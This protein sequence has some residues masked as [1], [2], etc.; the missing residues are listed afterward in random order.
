VDS[1][2]S[3]NDNIGVS[4]TRQAS[5][6]NVVVS[7]SSG[8]GIRGAGGGKLVIRDS[9]IEQNAGHGID[10]PNNLAGLKLRGTQVTA[11]WLS[12]LAW[13]DQIS[14]FVL[15]K[16]SVVDSTF[17][18]NGT[19]PLCGDA[20]TICADFDTCA[21]PKLVRSTCERSHVANSGKPGTSWGVCSLD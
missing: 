5:L 20:T 13:N 12:G 19:D 14:C 2:I 8:S 3:G 9:T 7:D 10:I 21:S 18:S 15:P 16:I 6:R 1:T 17:A 11:N 4:F